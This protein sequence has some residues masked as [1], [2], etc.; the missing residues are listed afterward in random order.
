MP[1][2]GPDDRFPR[3]VPVQPVPQGNDGKRGYEPDG[4]QKPDQ[5][6]MANAV[7]LSIATWQQG[8]PVR[9]RN[10]GPCWP[11]LDGAQ[12]LPR[13]AGGRL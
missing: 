12:S 7:R 9:R 4:N 6:R 10:P 2:I 3:A 11:A 8:R 13:S 1:C 5:G